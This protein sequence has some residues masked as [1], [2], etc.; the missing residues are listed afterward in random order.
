MDTTKFNQSTRRYNSNK[1]LSDV[2]ISNYIR[3]GKM[4]NELMKDEKINR[5]TSAKR[6]IKLIEEKEPNQNTRGNYYS[7]IIKYMQLTKKTTTRAYDIYIYVNKESIKT[8][9]KEKKEDKKLPEKLK[10]VKYNEGI[11]K[12][13]KTIKEQK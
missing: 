7:A 10:N 6:I 4:I 8:F 11:I 3:Y 13:I 1:K 12:F 5:I 9:Q 2:T